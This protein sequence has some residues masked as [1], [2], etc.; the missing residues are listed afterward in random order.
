LII[1]PKD[2]QMNYPFLFVPSYSNAKK[3]G[4]NYL[5]F[6]SFDFEYT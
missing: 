6:Q 4:V 3:T 5:A 2:E 1:T